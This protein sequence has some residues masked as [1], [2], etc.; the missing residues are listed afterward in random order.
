MRVTHSFWTKPALSKRWNINE[1]FK[2]N[3]WIYAL[4]F[5]YLQKIGVKKILHTD[6]FGKQLLD[7]L[8]YDE[9]HLTLDELNKLNIHERIWAAGKIWAQEAEPL[10]SVHIDGDV[11]LKTIKLRDRI[12]NSKKDLLTQNL[13]YDYDSDYFSNQYSIDEIKRII[14]SI[15]N[16]EINVYGNK[17]AVN[18]GIV[19]FNNQ[20]L[21]DTYIKKYKEYLNMVQNNL[22]TNLSN[23]MNYSPDLII[24]QWNL[25]NIIYS[26]NYTIDLLFPLNKTIQE[27]AKEIGYTHI[28]G[29]SK[30][31]RIEEIKKRLYEENIDIYNK[32]LEKLKE[33]ETI[34]PPEI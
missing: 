17:S 14:P 27:D 28:L 19:K 31:K 24:E 15:S 23:D 3:I 2:L 8:P 9:I 34:N 33:L 5:V 12:F 7:F 4:S 6:T 30:Y 21:K 11:L 1:Q 32:V 29:Q 18:C 25:Y 10:G 13:E 26:K 22:T 20:E 16:D